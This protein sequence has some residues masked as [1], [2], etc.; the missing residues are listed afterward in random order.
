MHR[1]RV[2]LLMVCIAPICFPEWYITP[3]D[4]RYGL[5]SHTWNTQ[6]WSSSLAAASVHAVCN[7]VP[8]PVGCSQMSSSATGSGQLTNN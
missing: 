4:F 1:H 5:R 6:G 8:L 7:K 2:M 3:P